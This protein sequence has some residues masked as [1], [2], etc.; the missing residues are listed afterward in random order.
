MPIHRK[1][2]T[3]G[4]ASR[5]ASAAGLYFLCA[6]LAGCVEGA[7]GVSMFGG[8]R[9]SEPAASPSGSGEIT[10]AAEDA[11][12]RDEDR[13]A[14]IDGLV[15]RRSVIPASGSYGKVAE[16]VLT[17][18]KG[19]AAAE[20]RV[21]RLKAEAKS[22]NWLPTIGPSVSLSSLS[23][24]ATSILVEQVLFDNGHRKAERAFAAADVEVAAVSLS[25]EMNMRVYEG[26]SYYVTAQRA[27]EQSL[28][29]DRAVERMT[30]YGRIMGLRVEGGLSDRSE[31]RVIR[32]KIAEMK[33]IASADREEIATAQA[34]L[35]AL[36]NTSLHGLSGLSVLR[37]SDGTVPLSVLQADGE[38]RRLVAEAK[39]QRAGFLPGLKAG[40]ALDGDGVTS[41]VRVSADQPFGF[42]TRSS[43]QAI[44]ATEEVAAQR[45]ASARDDAQRTL[46]LL[47]R[48]VATLTA[49]EVEGASV[50]RQTSSN[51]GLFTE[52][53]KVG[54][55]PL[56]ELV[57]IYESFS[58]M[59]REQAALKY[60][61]A[62]LQ[63]QIARTRGVLV[64]GERM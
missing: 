23:S 36:T 21:A 60:D 2:S 14:I 10:R 39:I 51:L 50:L 32:Q 47:E 52:Q 42:G 43:L 3:A 29:A 25:D 44:A 20:L 27:G 56:M 4:R 54:R 38:G 33:A 15:A 18:N 7:P 58:Q 48:R 19:P 55:R 16:A 40:A 53:Y 37:N 31:D 34:E 45:G 63:L 11:A 24:M 28:L 5:P 12:A 13:S 59:E 41:G 49:R 35:S 61:I 1:T 64:D 57:G 9:P 8:A 17:A 6:L 30:E 22:K 26:L 62:L 46:V